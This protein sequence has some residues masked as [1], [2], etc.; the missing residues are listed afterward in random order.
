M[1]ANAKLQRIQSE[2]CGRFRGCYMHEEG[3]SGVERIC[4][5]LLHVNRIINGRLTNIRS[6]CKHLRSVSC[7]RRTT[8]CVQMFKPK[9]LLWLVNG[10]KES[11]IMTQRFT[12][13][14]VNLPPSGTIQSTLTSYRLDSWPHPPRLPNTWIPTTILQKEAR[15][16]SGGVAGCYAAR[17]PGGLR[18]SS[19]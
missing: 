17:W 15:V 8:A 10:N 2:R 6:S 9:H 16:H 18:L 5:S 11:V 7:L 19:H 4:R 14:P 1:D 12:G 13:L 3:V